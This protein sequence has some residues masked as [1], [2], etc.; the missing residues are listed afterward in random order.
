LAKAAPEQHADIGDAWWDLAEK[1]SGPQQVAIRRHAADLY[2]DA[3]QTGTI[4][5]LKRSLLDQRIAPLRQLVFLPTLKEVEMVC[6]HKDWDA[7]RMKFKGE[8]CP[9]GMLLHPSTNSASYVT[10][11]LAREAA[12]FDARIGLTD[13]TRSSD[14]PLTFEVIGDGKVLWQSTPVKHWAD[15]QSCHIWISGVHR[16][17]LK[18]ECPGSNHSA[19]AFW[20][21]PSVTFK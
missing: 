1:E 11:D 15:S 19:H 4:V 5:G 10:Y 2:D 18:V 14:D 8:L 3:I 7:R 6:E 21:E 16:L 12:T 17:T 20:A 9:H 13:D